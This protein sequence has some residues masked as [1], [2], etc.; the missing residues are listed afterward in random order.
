MTLLG[1]RYELQNG[2]VLPTNPVTEI[3]AVALEGIRR[4]PAALLFIPCWQIHGKAFA[5]ASYSTTWH[6][7]SHTGFQLKEG[8]GNKNW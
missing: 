8:S 5:M 7:S 2:I 1:R 6:L 3:A 4:E